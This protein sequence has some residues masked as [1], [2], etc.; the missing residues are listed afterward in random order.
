MCPAVTGC[1]LL[2]NMLD[3]WSEHQEFSKA[4][5]LYKQAGLCLKA[6][7]NYHKAG[8]HDEAVAAMRQGNHFDELVSYL[9]M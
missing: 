5:P 2:I 6:A 7:D 3:L 4:A 1:T 8:K 9:R